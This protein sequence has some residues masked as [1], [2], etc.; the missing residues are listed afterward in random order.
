M[1]ILA[2]PKGYVE[3]YVREVA[4]LYQSILGGRILEQPELEVK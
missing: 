3:F 4:I 1:Y 2:T